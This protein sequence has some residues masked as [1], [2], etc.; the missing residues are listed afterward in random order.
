[1]TWADFVLFSA[2]EVLDHEIFGD[3][4]DACKDSAVLQAYMKNIRKIPAIAKYLAGR[5]ETVV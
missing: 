1:M 2:L 5:P 3:I 4:G